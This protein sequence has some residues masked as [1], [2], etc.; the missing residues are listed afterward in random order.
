V[1][2]PARSVGPVEQS[3]LLPALAGLTII[4]Y[5]ASS[6]YYLTLNVTVGD[7]WMLIALAIAMSSDRAMNG[8]LRIAGGTYG[9][10]AAT[11]SACL[12]ATAVGAADVMNSSSF[13]L[14]LL[15]VIWGVVPFVA[16]GIAEAPDPYR[17]IRRAGAG[18]LIFYGVGLVLLFG[19]RSEAILSQS[20]IGRVFQTF[21]THGLQLSLMSL[22]VAGLV[23]GTS[24][25]PTYLV[26][27]VGSSVPILL[28]ASRTGLLTFVLLG[29]LAMSFTVRSLRG[30][31]TVMAATG[32]LIATGYV[33]INSALAQDLLQIRVIS[34][35][36]FLE[37]DIRL[38]SI[39]V[40]LAAIRED[41]KTLLFGAGW[42]S[43]GAELVVHNLMLQVTHEGGL[44][45]L[46]P[47]MALF[48]LPLAWAVTGRDGD[49][50]RRPFVLMLMASILLFWSL[51][52]LVVERPYWLA[53]GIA[54]GI[55]HRQDVRDGD[56]IDASN[57][58]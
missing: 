6:P 14:Q 8:I 29:V 40:S 11:L 2:S 22:G 20:G 15:F 19:F 53:Y 16:A 47:L 42:G 32:L 57:R 3:R 36:S 5:V 1:T 10:V 55:A 17:F 50:I 30:L 48:A 38:R 43:S 34:A 33:L 23:F 35:A 56:G 9:L 39:G 13:V 54:L 49:P 46:L 7:I 41:P 51:N 24:R 31:G 52:A 26:L 28:N 58:D 18:Y 37:D 4:I 25:R 27:L 12:L 21:T 45:V 44:L